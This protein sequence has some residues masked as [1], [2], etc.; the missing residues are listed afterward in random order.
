MAGETPITDMAFNG[1][2]LVRLAEKMLK[3]EQKAVEKL[4]Q[5]FEE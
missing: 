4:T 5:A 2:A 3:K 1:V